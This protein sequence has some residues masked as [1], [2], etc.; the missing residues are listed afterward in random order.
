MCLVLEVSRA[1]YYRWCKRPLSKR[2]QQDSELKEKIA[3][4]HQKSRGTYGSPRIY[5]E[6]CQQGYRVGQNRV[7]RLMREEGISAVHKR[8]Y[9]VTTDSSHK[10]PVAENRLNREFT[11]D[12]PNT[13][14]VSDIT[15]IPTAEGW[16]YLAVIMDLYSRKIIG[17]AMDKRITRELVLNALEMAILQRNPKR[18]LLLHSDRGSQY[19]S[20]EYQALLWRK[21]II[22]SM[23]NKGNCW[24]NAVMESFFRTL[25][26]ELI[27]R[28]T[29]DS[30]LEA[31]RD[32]F[33]YIEAFYNRKRLHS[34]IGY[35]S[36]E[37]Y[38]N[39]RMVA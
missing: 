17:W 14:W 4:I 37:N 9:K 3:Q 26:V 20:Y 39:W 24:D 22:C 19:A 35:L 31:Q 15:Y 25:K 10:L 11:A 16:L 23:S 32:I 7:E 28:A 2:K 13:S 18:G 1:G 38:E 12:R 21:G 34:A 8:K 33:E 29:Y 5:K 6:L 36:P 27:Y 30:R